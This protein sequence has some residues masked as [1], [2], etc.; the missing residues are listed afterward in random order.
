MKNSLDD[1]LLHLEEKLAHLERLVEKLNQASLEQELRLER[2]LKA[3]DAV[4]QS[5]AAAHSSDS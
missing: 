5:L 3:L 1:R 4:Q 2:T